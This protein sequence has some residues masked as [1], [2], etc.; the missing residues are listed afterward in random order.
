[1][2]LGDL[3][4]TTHA[5]PDVPKNT[6]ALIINSFDVYAMANAMAKERYADFPA[7]WEVQLTNG[8]KR[9]YLA[10]DLEVIK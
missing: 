4:K 6:L 7:I 3:V 10:R 1:M 9:R 5:T 2:Q 8:Y